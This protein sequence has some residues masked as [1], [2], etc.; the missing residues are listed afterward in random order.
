[1][2]NFKQTWLKRW[3]IAIVLV[4]LCGG[5]GLAASADIF[6]E[7]KAAGKGMLVYAYGSDWSASGREVLKVFRS[8]AFVQALTNRYV[9]GVLDD[10]DRVTDAIKRANAWAKRGDLGS[11]R[12]PALFASDA[13]GRGFLALEN[14]PITT[15]AAD[16]KRR[17]QAAEAVHAR[18]LYLCAQAGVCA[19]PLREAEFYGE[20]L[21]LF[22]QGVGDARVIEA[23]CLGA[24]F[25]KLKKVDP[26]DQTGWQRRFTLGNCTS[27]IKELNALREAERFDEAKAFLARET[28]KPA[29][30]L[31]LNQKQG[32]KLLA[33]ALYRLDLGKKAENVKLLDEVAAMGADTFWGKA[34]VGFLLREEAPEAKKYLKAAPKAAVL[35]ARSAVDGA[36][37]AAA[38]TAR[39][40]ADCAVLD[41]ISAH[42]L[43]P[44]LPLSVRT[45][46]VRAFILSETSTNA[47][48]QICHRAGGHAFL[49]RFFADR[50]WM[51]AFAGSGH[52]HFGGGAALQNLETFVFNL[53]EVEKDPLLRRAATA[54][55]LNFPAA[56]SNQVNTVK[57][58]AIFRDLARSGRLHD[59]VQHLDVYGWRYLLFPWDRTKPEDLL[60]LNAFANCSYAR[61][62]KQGWQVPYRL[63]N[64]FG[65]SVFKAAYYQPWAHTDTRYTVATEIGGVCNM[66]SSFAVTLGHA[67]GLMAVT[68]GQPAHCAF[69]VRPQK[70]G[71]KRWEKHYNIKPYTRGKWSIFM[72]WGGYHN[73]L[74]GEELYEETPLEAREFP[75]WFAG[76][77]RTAARLGGRE[78]YRDEVGAL[79][80]HAME[81]VPG[82]LHAA[83]DWAWYLEEVAPR[84]V[85]RWSALGEAVLKT[86]PN[87]IPGN[88][89]LLNKMFDVF[90]QAG[91]PELRRAWVK[92]FLEATKEE[93][94]RYPEPQDFGYVLDVF[95]SAF[96]SS[97]QELFD[98]YL[99]ALETQKTSKDYFAQILQRGV[100]RYLGRAKYEERF[101]AAVAAAL[102]ST[103]VRDV[104]PWRALISQ[105]EARDNPSAVQRLR[106]AMAKFFPLPA[107]RPGAAAYP[108]A[109]FGGKLVSDR[110][111]VRMTKA[112]RHDQSERHG[113]LLD[114]SPL[115]VAKAGPPAVAAMDDGDLWIG[116]RLGG[117]TE[118]AGVRVVG[119]KLPALTVEISDDG[120][121][122]QSLGAMTVTA[123]EARL[124][125]SKTPKRARFIVVKPVAPSKRAT[126]ALEKFLVYGKRLY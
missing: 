117:D 64:C 32:V 39:L 52:L 97:S 94:G 49:E 37:A 54:F 48:A 109:D 4:G 78:T 58:L 101:F 100:K 119:P 21:H 60:A 63:R 57:T 46:L 79:Y 13:E 33:Y 113:E 1:M 98:I 85:E 126:F 112:S 96:R 56:A 95:D 3:G 15:T 28:A 69:L 87:K 125:L 76:A 124:D 50:E 59:R 53:P 114:A 67:H 68:A 107:A 41:K 20:A 8:P 74:L 99:E 111:L 116:Q 89:E 34:A 43:T 118:I 12:L 29:A 103:D 24:V 18:A 44:A 120:E 91:K 90:V 14:L 66:I 17:I 30:H 47:I 105:M 26:L 88:I 80:R 65:E 51:E 82:H 6:S 40:R 84:S 83:M 7:A 123:T 62:F 104:K 121:T 25:A 38:W 73:I 45:S 2:K 106:E 11:V 110:S 10:A 81:T 102:G 27:L 108:E 9:F 71:P 36:R 75:R 92:R 16:L 70:G 35:K 61:L 23:T 19:N 31:T 5:W 77:R 42:D 72:K 122:W 55:S 93:E 115:R 22:A 86:M